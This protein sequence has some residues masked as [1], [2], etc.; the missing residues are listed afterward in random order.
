MT[1]SE[2]E[3][4]RIIT[5]SINEELRKVINESIAH[6]NCYGV[7]RGLLEY[8]INER[9]DILIVENRSVAAYVYRNEIKQIN[10]FLSNFISNGELGDYYINLNEYGTFI[11]WA[12]EFVLW[13]EVKN[14]EEDAEYF[15]I[16]NSQTSDKQRYRICYFRLVLGRCQP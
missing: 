2:K 8:R 12:K 14:E 15:H 16:T 1:V 10:S 9:E 6:A 13:I 4:D 11:D 3:I 7:P 5:S